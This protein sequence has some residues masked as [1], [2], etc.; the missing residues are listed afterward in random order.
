M[1]ASYPSSIRIFTSKAN[2]T[3]IIDASHPNFLQEEVVAIESTLGVSPNVS[4][5]PSSAGTFN[6]TSTT[7]ATV[8]ARL[9]NIETGV[10]SD[11]HTQYIR[12]AGDS[13][14]IVAVSSST[15]KPLILRGAAGQSVALQEWQNSSST[16]LASVSS[17]GSITAASFVKS[18]GTSAQFLMAD[19]S[20][21][22]TANYTTFSVN[23]T[24]KTAA[25]TL[26]AG[27][28]NTLVQMNGAFAFTVDTSLSGATV[29][30][31]I[32]LLALTSGVSV[33]AVGVTVNGTPGLKLR[34]AYSSATLICLGTNNWV[35]VGDLS[36]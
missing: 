17:A 6:A 32:H 26:A 25:Y 15:V 16:V 34:T 29:G 8:S 23:T 7:F 10:V 35:L 20:T 14:N 4:T 33:S 36:A 19:G 5:A 3:D 1:A 18:G 11:A 2:V 24:A 9:A 30:T 22:S 27:D 13:A 28:Y 21:L 12:K 31:Q